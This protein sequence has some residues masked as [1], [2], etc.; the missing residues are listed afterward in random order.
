[1][2]RE[3]V[4]VRVRARRRKVWL[5][6]LGPLAS[7]LVVLGVV[8]LYGQL[9]GDA[10][11]TPGAAVPAA[12]L[13]QE[14]TA[15]LRPVVLPQDDAPH[16]TG[17][18]WWYYNGHLRGDNGEAY[19][20]HVAVFLHDGVV[21]HTVFHGSLNDH[22]SGQRFTGQLRT[23]GIPTSKTVD[24]FD[25]KHEGWRVAGAGAVHSLA[26]HDKN[27]SIDLDLRDA[28]QPLLH[29][30]AGSNT[31]GLLDFG[32]GGISYYYSRPRIAAK[33]SVTTAGTRHAVQGEVWFDH[34]WGDFDGAGLAWNWYAL[35]MDDGS[36]LMLYQLFGS[37][38]QLITTTGTVASAQGVR[39]L[40][41]SDIQLVPQGR[42]TSPKT[43]ISYPAAWQVR[44]PLGTL[45]VQPL[46]ADSE[47]EAL[48]TT[49]NVYWEGP[50][51][52]TGAATGKG[53]LEMSGYDRTQA[54][55]A[56][57]SSAIK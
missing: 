1:M 54:P 34:Q 44:L 30:A 35:Q 9:L 10:P 28:G 2:M 50:V 5:R 41:A 39:A 25:F 14:R 46:R 29:R 45:N 23:A 16:A 49:F 55:G 18:E 51:A 38:G 11:Q 52:V 40:A 19:S 15:A 6:Y 3:R 13:P 20:F 12:A 22:R 31:P 42:W 7:L 33:G 27:F 4:R 36:D 8:W 48:E 57:V 32:P 17:M 53:F 37:Q 21:R 56:V 24:G 43:R 47:F 26:V